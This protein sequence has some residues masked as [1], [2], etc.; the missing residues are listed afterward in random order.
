MYEYNNRLN[1]QYVLDIERLKQDAATFSIRLKNYVKAKKVD[2]K[3]YE[4][5]HKGDPI[6]ESKAYL[7]VKET[8]L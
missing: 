3:A 4:E 1:A 7:K 6:F 8:F 2:W 5:K